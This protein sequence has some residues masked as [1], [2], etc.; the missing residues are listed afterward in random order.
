LR[1]WW[2][3]S[4]LEQVDKCNVEDKD[5]HGCKYDNDSH[6]GSSGELEVE[7]YT[8]RSDSD[9]YRTTIEKV[10]ITVF[11]SDFIV[12]DDSTHLGMLLKLKCTS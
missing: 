5:H 8:D 3:W 4:S 2:C 10:F 6:D 11:V 12:C 1:W 9:N 7:G